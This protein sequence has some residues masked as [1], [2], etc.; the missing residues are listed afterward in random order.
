MEKTPLRPQQV[1]EMKAW[2]SKWQTFRSKLLVLMTSVRQTIEFPTI[3]RPEQRTEAWRECLEEMEQIGESI[4]PFIEN[5]DYEI[6][7]VFAAKYMDSVSK[8]FHSANN[9]LKVLATEDLNQERAKELEKKMEIFK[10]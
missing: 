3:A 5:T 7:Q 6:A 10:L 2:I 1:Q 4:K 8:S 9:K